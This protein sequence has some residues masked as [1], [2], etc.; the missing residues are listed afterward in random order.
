MRPVQTVAASTIRVS[1]NAI[2]AGALSNKTTHALLSKSRKR[3][4]KVKPRLC[5]IPQ[6]PRL[7]IEG[8]V[9]FMYIF[10]TI[11]TFRLCPAAR[12]LAGQ[13]TFQNH[14]IVYKPQINPRG[15]IRYE[16]EASAYI[17]R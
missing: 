9:V 14:S 11:H 4:K 8:L 3:F 10:P 7:E 17:S 15:Y 5:P 1:I 2:T 6:S 16:T 13:Q 12:A